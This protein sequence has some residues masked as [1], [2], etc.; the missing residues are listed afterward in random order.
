MPALPKLLKPSVTSEIEI[1]IGIASL[2]L[3]AVS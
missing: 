3:G 2:L 1:Q